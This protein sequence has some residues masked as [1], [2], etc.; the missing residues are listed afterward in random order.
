[1]ATPDDPAD[2]Y[3]PI[4]IIGSARIGSAGELDERTKELLELLPDDKREELLAVIR[5]DFREI[6]ANAPRGKLDNIRAAL[7]RPDFVG[8]LPPTV[9]A[10]L[11]ARLARDESTV[12]I[13]VWLQEN[14]PDA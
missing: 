1:V 12:D 6:L 11:R 8:L 5:L 13:L 10:E 4:S 9:E 3:R 7:Q 14:V 2:K